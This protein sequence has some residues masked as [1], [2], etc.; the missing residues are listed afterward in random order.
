[1]ISPPEAYVIA[2]RKA[3]EKDEM[4]GLPVP[5]RRPLLMPLRPLRTRHPRNTPSPSL[6]SMALPL[7]QPSAV[8]LAHPT[9]RRGER[10]CPRKKR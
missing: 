8:P 3:C 6:A 9:R 4:K 10:G 5:S 1:M 7:P 2:Y